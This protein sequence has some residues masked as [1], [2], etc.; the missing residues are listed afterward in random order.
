MQCPYRKA[1]AATLSSRD[2]ESLS[3]V[4]HGLWY[5]IAPVHKAHTAGSLAYVIARI[6]SNGLSFRCVPCLD[7]AP[8]TRAAR[9][10]LSCYTVWHFATEGTPDPEVGDKPIVAVREGSIYADVDP[11]VGF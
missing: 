1:S 7:D 10:G 8:E 11:E 3:T 9:L 4:T 6:A 2:P 5:T